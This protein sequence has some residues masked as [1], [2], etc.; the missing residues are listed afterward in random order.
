MPLS[1]KNYN[2]MIK[3]NL[4]LIFLSLFSLST[5]HAQNN[6]VKLDG[7]AAVVGKN[8]VLDSEIAAYKL[9]LEQQSEGK[10][11]ISDCEMLE[12]IMERK[13]LSHHAVI[14][15]VAVTEPEINTRVEQKI[16][17][18]LEQL[19]SEEKLYNFYGFNNMADLRKEFVEV[20]REL[21]LVQRMQAKLT[22]EVDVTPEEVR[23]YYQSLEKTNDVPEI[24]AEIELAQI[25]RH[26]KP[27]EEEKER[28]I[29]RLN[30]L[31][32]QIQNGESFKMKAILFSDDP[33]ASSQGQGQGGLYT[34]TRESRFITEFKEVAFGLDEG[35]I[36]DPF[37]SSF[38][39]HIIQVEKIKGK[40]RDVRHILI[41]PEVTEERTQQ[42]K[43]S[44]A[45][46][47]KDILENKLTFKEAVHKYSEEK[48]T[49]GTDGFLINPQTNDT[50]FEMTKMDPELYSRISTLEP[51][52]IS[53]VF[54]DVDRGGG[55]RMFKII[56]MKSKTPA[57][58]ADLVKD[59]VKIQNL[60]LQKKRE[61]T[62][63]KWIKSVMDDTYININNAHQHCDFKYNW[64]KI[65]N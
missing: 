32:K 16:A 42:V 46:I 40:Q 6:R 31:K 57:H 1:K 63:S 39:F 52:Q 3:S 30:E 29:A 10:V 55:E 19:G 54:F 9:E 35:E 51:G 33:A 43:D 23:N 5:I 61:E 26:V 44:L 50:K 59:Y 64:K 18:F 34:I 2:S 8:I 53:D 56:Y 60:A 58:K 14:D 37:E 48:I 41:Q 38:G 13:L 24:G 4:T 27:S 20:E 12:Q 11:D 25:V 22:E 15:S 36:S 7:V 49:K 45:N 62:I 28:I 21:L 47:R 65:A 17:F